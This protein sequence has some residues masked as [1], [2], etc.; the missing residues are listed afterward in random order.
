MSGFERGPLQTFE[1]VWTGGHTEIIEA[2]QVSYSGG[3]IF[4]PDR[5]ESIQF[6]GEFD[7]SWLLVLRV[8]GDDI[9]SIR[10]LTKTEQSA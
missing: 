7:G 4:A 9:R 6:H 10:N 3:A 1:I 5:P 8:L 2:H